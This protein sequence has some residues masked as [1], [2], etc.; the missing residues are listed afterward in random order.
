ME[1]LKVV[2]NI[3][4]I[5]DNNQILIKDIV[6]E[7]LEYNRPY[8]I[9]GQ[10]FRIK[11]ADGEKSLDLSSYQGLEYLR[12]EAVWDETEENIGVVKDE[13]A[14]F[15]IQINGGANPWMKQTRF[16][17]EKPVGIV[18]IKVR[19]PDNTNNKAVRVKTILS[20]TGV[21]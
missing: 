4:K 12:L 2:T 9:D 15:E 1:R 19:N 16:S 3:S 5:G 21:A 13:P 6:S 8:G 20:A 7:S 11:N 17:L 18:S 14:P 10:D